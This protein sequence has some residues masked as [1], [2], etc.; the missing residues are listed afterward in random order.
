MQA[1]IQNTAKQGV[2]SRTDLQLNRTNIDRYC[3]TFPGEPI[4]ASLHS[5]W[6]TTWKFKR[7][8]QLQQR[9]GPAQQPIFLNGRRLHS[10]SSTKS[11]PPVPAVCPRH[12][13][14]ITLAPAFSGKR[15]RNHGRRLA[16]RART[17]VY[18]RPF[19]GPMVLP[20]AVMLR[21]KK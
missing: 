19:K 12:I 5:I 2:P 21:G 15:T 13:P 7:K 18:V 8:N 3:H 14:T 4:R 6:P 1:V 20:K 10:L 11:L 16:L 17:S 9:L